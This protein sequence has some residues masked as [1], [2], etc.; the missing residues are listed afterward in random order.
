[1]V[2]IGAMLEGWDSP[3]SLTAFSTFDQLAGGWD[4]GGALHQL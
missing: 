1:V 2:E 4:G 3:A